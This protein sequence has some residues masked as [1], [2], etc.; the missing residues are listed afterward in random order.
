MPQELVNLATL[1]ESMME[2]WDWFLELNNTRSSGMG[3]SPITFTE[4]KS[5]FD[6]Y[7]IDATVTEIQL[8]KMI[9]NIALSMSRQQ[10]EENKNKN[11]QKQK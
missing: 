2:V 9:D 11:K 10:D 8:I 5:Y 6:L 1:P 4:I 7:N 3:V